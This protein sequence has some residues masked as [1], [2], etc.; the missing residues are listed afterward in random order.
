MERDESSWFIYTEDVVFS[1]KQLL[2]AAGAAE[3]PVPIPGWTLLGV[4]SVGAAQVITK[5]HRVKP[6]DRGIIIGVNVLSAAIAMELHLAG[7]DIAAMALPPLHRI[8]TKHARPKEIVEA[9][10]HS[11]YLAPSK[12]LQIGSKFMT[13]PLM[14]SLGSPFT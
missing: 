13:N 6:G 8:T 10:L 4:M 14:R 3:S 7:I 2:L 9:L 1:S 5:V 12:L 11:S